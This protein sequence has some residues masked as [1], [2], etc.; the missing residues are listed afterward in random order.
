[1][2]CST[3]LALEYGASPV[4]VAALIV[5]IVAA[6]MTVGGVIHAILAWRNG[7][8][9]VAGRIHFSL[10]TLALVSLAWQLNQWNLL[11]FRV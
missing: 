6:V 10:V 3:T 4:L 2:P 9:S 8:G 1:V 11:G 5:D 7:H